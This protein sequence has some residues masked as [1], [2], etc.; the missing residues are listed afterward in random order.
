MTATMQKGDK[1]RAESKALEENDVILRQAREAA[2]APLPPEPGEITGLE[3][4]DE[5]SPTRGTSAAPRC[6]TTCPTRNWGR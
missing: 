2:S 3:R 5:Q 6:T 1:A 4:L